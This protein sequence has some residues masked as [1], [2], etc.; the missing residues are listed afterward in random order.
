MLNLRL[1]PD[2]KMLDDLVVIGYGSKDKKSLTS[3]IS[4][5]KNDNIERLAQSASTVDGSNC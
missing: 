2:C 1:V 5:L 4:S 3:S